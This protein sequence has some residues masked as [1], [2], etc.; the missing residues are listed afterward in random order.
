MKKF[1]LCLLI[2][3]CLTHSIA[4]FADDNDGVSASPKQNQIKAPT[5]RE[6]FRGLVKGIEDNILRFPGTASVETRSFGKGYRV[7]EVAL[8]VKGI[9]SLR[10][11]VNNK[12]IEGTS[13]T[14]LPMQ[15]AVRIDPSKPNGVDLS[16]LKV[17]FLS[18][19]GKKTQVGLDAFNFEFFGIK[20][21][22]KDLNLGRLWGISF[23]EA[24]IRQIFD[25]SEDG[26]ARI[27]FEG[28]VELGIDL[29]ESE[30]HPQDDEISAL[31]GEGGNAELRG[32][33]GF[34]F[35]KKLKLVFGGEWDKFN[36]AD[37]GT[38]LPVRRRYSR[39]YYGG[40]LEWAMSDRWKMNLKLGKDFYYNQTRAS[41]PEDS[42]R[43]EDVKIEKLPDEEGFSTN[44]GLSF[45]W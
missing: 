3:G 11:Q 30:I 16:K 22:N 25:L 20:Y 14:F 44:A 39:A 31:D 32:A 23:V 5:P 29:A 12:S 1:I 35:N 27:V 4:L 33:A 15:I 43:L 6:F 42:D 45:E 21:E 26:D 34:I 19:N 13:L 17:R 41:N 9:A 38:N 28:G 10:D 2:A 24:D 18:V 7:Y 36:R 37:L 8:K 40:A